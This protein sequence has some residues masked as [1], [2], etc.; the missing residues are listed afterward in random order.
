MTQGRQRWDGLQTLGLCA[1]VMGGVLVM[2][3]VLEHW[4][5]GEWGGAAPR[6]AADTANE[7]ERGRSLSEIPDVVMTG[8]QFLHALPK[9]EARPVWRLT[10]ST[11]A[12]FEQRQ[13]ADLQMIQAAFQPEQESAQ[14]VLSSEQGRFDLKRL[15]FEVS[16]QAEPVIM[17]LA[18][19]Y[20]LA[21]SRLTWDNA[22]ARLTSDQAVTISGE[23]LTVSGVGF[24]WAQPAGT[25][26]IHHDVKT[27]IT[28]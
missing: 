25:V 10:A 11:A 19:Q 22:A 17:Q 14:V 9:P 16:G 6:R 23:G 8:F 4:E 15:N 21:T 7:G 20:R 24:E 5:R 2:D 13:E 26:S 28:P 18:G 27:V 3:A 1:I 12:L